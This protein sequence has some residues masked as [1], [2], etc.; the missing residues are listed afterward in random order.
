MRDLKRPA[1]IIAWLSLGLS[2]STNAAD[3]EK[4]AGSTRSWEIRLA[5]KA[6]F[7]VRIN[8][9]GSV[10]GNHWRG[11]FKDV[12]SSTVCTFE[13][14]EDFIWWQS[15]LVVGCGDRRLEYRMFAPSLSTSTPPDYATM[16]IMVKLRV[17]EEVHTWIA[18]AAKVSDP[19]ALEAAKKDVRRLPAPFLQALRDMRLLASTEFARVNGPSPSMIDA[20]VELVDDSPAEVRAEAIVALPADVA[21]G[22][23]REAAASK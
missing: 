16:Q 8:R 9:V 4:P 11:I 10:A 20:V 5:S 6:E 3:P 21:D 19:K 15:S 22:L 7:Q 13:E 1:T 23:V 18:G 12:S 14:V 2:L 17:G